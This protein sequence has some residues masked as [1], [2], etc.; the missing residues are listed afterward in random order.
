[1]LEKLSQLTCIIRSCP[2]QTGVREGGNPARGSGGISPPRRVN[3]CAQCGQSS[4][5]SQKHAQTSSQ[6]P[7]PTEPESST[8]RRGN[9]RSPGQK[10][11]GKVSHA[12]CRWQNQRLSPTNAV[13]VTAALSQGREH[14]AG[15]VC[16]FIEQTDS[17]P[18]HRAARAHRSCLLNLSFFRTAE[19]VFGHRAGQDTRLSSRD[20]T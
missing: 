1:M 10:S 6:S 18:L 11:H 13:S 3:L 9:V 17:S 2:E 19:C 16:S 20:E 15:V 8:P 4:E 5:L 12:G 14:I 7:Q